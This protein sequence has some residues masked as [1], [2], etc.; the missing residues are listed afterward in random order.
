[1]WSSEYDAPGW[2]TKI[3]SK[4]YCKAH[5]IMKKYD[6]NGAADW[7]L[8]EKEFYNALKGENPKAIAGKNY[9]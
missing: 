5:D 8:D 9:Q 7:M 1:M 2:E 4:Y 3:E 6:K